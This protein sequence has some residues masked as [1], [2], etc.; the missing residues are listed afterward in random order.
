[1]YIEAIHEVFFRFLTYDNSLQHVHNSVMKN[2]I[3]CKRSKCLCRPQSQPHVVAYQNVWCMGGVGLITWTPRGRCC[4][5]GTPLTLYTQGCTA[6]RTYCCHNISLNLQNI[7]IH[8]NQ[9][10]TYSFIHQ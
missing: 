1:M 10:E 4:I 9:F 2:S 7:I 5:L 3:T 6:Y 8:F